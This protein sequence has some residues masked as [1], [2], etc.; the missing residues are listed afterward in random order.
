MKLYGCNKMKITEENITQLIDYWGNRT[1]KDN[2]PS[3]MKITVSDVREW[4]NGFLNKNGKHFK[5]GKIFYKTK[6][7]PNFN[8]R[9]GI[10]YATY[11]PYLCMDYG[12]KGFESV[13][14]KS[15][16]LENGEIF[17]NLSKYNLCGDK[18]LSLTDYY[19]KCNHLTNGC[20]QSGKHY[21][22]LTLIDNLIDDF[23]NGGHIYWCV[24]TANSIVEVK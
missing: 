2:I 6:G 11:Y 23:K 13:R 14:I 16:I 8:R 5:T 24:I 1:T 18:K 4:F 3:E 12:R 21:N 17:F 9:V 10:G 19:N 22:M 15:I 20:A 7:L